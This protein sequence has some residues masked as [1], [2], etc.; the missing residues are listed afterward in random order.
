M[1]LRETVE[2]YLTKS[3]NW[4]RA[5]GKGIYIW[6]D[7]RYAERYGEP[8]RG[9]KTEEAVYREMLYEEEEEEA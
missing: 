4:S 2:D 5:P 1:N 3:P 9:M 8:P 7:G 6:L